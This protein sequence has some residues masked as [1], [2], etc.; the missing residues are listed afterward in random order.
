M[1]NNFKIGKLFDDSFESMPQNEIEANLE[2]IAYNITEEDYT[3]TLSED[4]L[5]VRKTS[6]AEVS[7][8]LAA[9]EEEKK[10]I[11]DKHKLKVK[12]PKSEQ[13]SLLESI[14]HRSERMYGKLF[15]I[16]EPEDNMM[17][18]F[19]STGQ[20]VNMRAMLPSEKQTKLRT[21]KNGTD[22]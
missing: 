22:E 2:S 9:L 16:D 14:K 21:L 13:A 3:R 11:M 5:N 15:A 12:G 17:Y 18:F 4:E 10:E 20:C 19:D 1:K 7:I 8:K 6:L